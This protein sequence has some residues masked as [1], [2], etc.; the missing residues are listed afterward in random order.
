MTELTELYAGERRTQIIA[1][2]PEDFSQEDLV[3]HQVT[4]VSVSQ[5]GYIKR[6]PLA[7]YRKQHRGGSGV[8]AMTTRNEDAVCK[9]LVIDT[10]DSLLFFTDKGRVFSLKAHEV[11]ERSREWRGLPLRNLIQIEPAEEVT[12]IVA[13]TGFDR[14]FLL[15]ATA[16]GQIKKAA[17]SE[18]ASVRRAGLI[19]FNL[20]KD[21]ELVLAT[22]A[23]AGDDVLVVSD[24]GK[25]V[26]F[27][28]D[29]LRGASRGSGGVRA[30]DLPAGGRLVGL[31]TVRPGQDF[32][33]VTAEGFGKRTPED[34]FPQKGRGGKGMIA[35][36][37]SDKTGPLMSL[38]Q[39]SGEE[40]VVLISGTGKFIR[41]SVSSIPAYSRSTQGVT[42]MNTK[43]TGVAAVAVVDISRE[44]G[45][46][47]PPDE[48]TDPAPES[49]AANGGP[50]PGGAGKKTPAGGAGKKTPAGGAGK[51]TPAGGA[52]KKTPAG[53]AGKK[54]PAGGAGTGGK[55]KAAPKPRRRARKRGNGRA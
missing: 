48:P 45:E 47:P 42:V 32:L 20:R 28:I 14:D 49:S 23:H 29:S 35:H 43:G 50:A 21:D 2:D 27:A 7:T 6:M 16:Q 37:V 5:A 17:L 54:T 22:A 26:R 4:V 30:I 12:A 39:V 33:M 24:G 13:A 40:E 8:T 9:L 25:G 31:E 36:K 19:A 1:Q 55:A 10:H 46:G 34:E 18:F 53:G 3:A 51:K 44:Y 38:H 41:T 11:E 15:L 52:G